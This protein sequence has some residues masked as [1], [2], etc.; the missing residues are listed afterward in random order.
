MNEKKVKVLLSAYNGE[1]Y[2]KEQV[3]SVL[4]QTYSNLE[5]YIRDDGSKDGTLE[6]LK[7]YQKQEKVHI[8][9]GKNI[10]FI[11][12]FFKLI[13]EC[14]EAD[15]YAFADQDDA[16][17]PEKIA[18]AVERL[19]QEEQNQ[20]LLYFSNYDFYDGEMNFKEHGKLPAMEPSFHNAIVDCMT[21][22][23][24][25]VFNQAAHDKMEEH[26]PKYSCGH[27]WW[28]YMICSGMG[29][30]L[31]DEKVTVK[32]R[33]HEKN[34]SPGGMDFIKFQIWRFRKFFLNDYFSNIRKQMREF[35]SL[36]ADQLTLEDKNL[37]YLFT[38]K[39]YSIKNA[40][41]KICYPKRFRCGII[42]ELFV[43]FIFLIGKL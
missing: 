32:Y 41:K 18:M 21:L 14:G 28:T 34:V 13:S 39:K 10:G 27:D 43:R 23:F 38:N 12:S 30:V 37:L 31:F 26:I 36:Y 29:K 40:W 16:W 42:D 35:Y 24:N 6:V 8:I 9:K 5:L 7:Q 19:N 17:L 4:Q 15:Y 3:D 1:K 25:S 22:G 11:Q 33:R 20:P 2:I